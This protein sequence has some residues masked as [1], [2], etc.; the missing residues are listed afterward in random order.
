MRKLLS[1]NLHLEVSVEDK[2]VA[3][4]LSAVANLAWAWQK[5][6]VDYDDYLLRTSQLLHGEVGANM[7]KLRTMTALPR[8]QTG[9]NVSIRDNAVM[10]VAKPLVKG[11]VSTATPVCIIKLI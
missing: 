8:S 1:P 7:M 10:M 11:G 3:V 9:V 4:V 2:N 6:S 5:S